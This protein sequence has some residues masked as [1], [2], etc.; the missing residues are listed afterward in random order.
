MSKIIPLGDRLLIELDPVVEKQIRGLWIP[1][2]TSIP[3]RQ[4]TVIRVGDEVTRFKAED[5]ILVSYLAGLSIDNP[6]LADGPSKWE[7]I[8][9]VTEQEIPAKVEV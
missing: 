6:E 3:L 2:K 8:R 7:T 4:A 5:R 1:D 9:I